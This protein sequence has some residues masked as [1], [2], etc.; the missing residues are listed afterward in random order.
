MIRKL[1]ITEMERL[2]PEEFHQ[3]SKTPLVVVL[4]NVRS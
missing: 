2:S 4:D 1:H 3:A